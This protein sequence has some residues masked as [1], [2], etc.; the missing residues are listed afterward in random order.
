MRRSSG[1]FEIEVFSLVMKQPEEVT[2]RVRSG[3]GVGFLFSVCHAEQTNVRKEHTTSF[4]R[5]L[6]KASSGPLQE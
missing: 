6:L 2:Q 1:I 4:Q 3:K 5:R